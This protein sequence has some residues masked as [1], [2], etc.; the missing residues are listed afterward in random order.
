MR[1]NAE[2]AVRCCPCL[3][4]IKRKQACIKDVW[5]NKLNRYKRTM[6]SSRELYSSTGDERIA[7][8]RCPTG[9][10]DA[11]TKK[12]DGCFIFWHATACIFLPEYLYCSRVA[13][14]DVA[15]R[16]TTKTNVDAI[17]ALPAIAEQAYMPAI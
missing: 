2:Q 10:T 15:G 5:W 1:Q 7:T 6:G 9:V 12:L 11:G 17:E 16:P 3:L 4:G 13:A 8:Q 14:A